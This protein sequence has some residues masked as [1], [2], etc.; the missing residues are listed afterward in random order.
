MQQMFFLAF[1][2]FYI[3]EFAAGYFYKNTY[4]REI[5][6]SV[7]VTAPISTS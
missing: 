5:N 4:G 1:N 3:T 2:S 6:V 7:I